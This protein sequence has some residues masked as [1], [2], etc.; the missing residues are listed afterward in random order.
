MHRP[1][2]PRKRQLPPRSVSPTRSP[3]P[4]SDRASAL[5]GALSVPPACDGV[6]V[7]TVPASAEWTTAELLCVLH[8]LV[9][10]SSIPQ[11]DDT[12]GAPND[13]Q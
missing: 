10:S 7:Y 8:D 3:S 2:E 11:P 4:T 9:R 1:Q 12:A 5:H 13:A 6:Y